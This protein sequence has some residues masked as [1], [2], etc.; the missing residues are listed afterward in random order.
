MVK[1]HTK[2]PHKIWTE[3][4]IVLSSSFFSFLSLSV[5]LTH[6]QYKR[7]R[8]HSSEENNEETGDS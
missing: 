2:K 7:E 4:K 5:C 1:K 3:S 6:T 8:E